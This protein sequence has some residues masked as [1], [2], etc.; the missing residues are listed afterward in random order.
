MLIRRLAVVV[1]LTAIIPACG[2]ISSPSENTVEMFPGT[3]AVGGQGPTHNFSAS[4]TGEF[5]VTITALTPDPNVFLGIAVGQQTGG[6]CSAI[7]LGGYVNNFAQRDRQALGG[8]IQKGNYCVGVYD[9]GYLTQ[10]ANYTLR[11]S[12]P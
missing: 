8:Q 2:G 4:K 1:F 3:V 7:N 10:A 12:H 6:G 11:V 5:F 9:V